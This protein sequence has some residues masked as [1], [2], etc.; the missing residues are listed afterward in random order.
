MN[1][2]QILI[3]AFLISLSICAL[4]STQ[5][6]AAVLSITVS[7]E[8]PITMD[9]GQVQMFTATPNG[10]SGS[11]SVQWN[12]DGSPVGSDSPNYS[13]SATSTG[14]HLI[15]VFV[16]DFT[17]NAQDSV[18]VTVAAPPTVSIA[19]N[20]PIKMDVGQVQVFTATSIGGSGTIKY[21]WYLGGSVVS[22]ATGSTYSFSPAAAGSYLVTC[23]VTDSASSPVTSP[24]SNA[25]SVVVNP[26]LVA[27]TVSAS[28]STD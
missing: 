13:F 9:V 16:T 5:V 2:S 8:G 22:G 28:A 12:L 14:P 19:P 11:L 18:S 4:A 15:T 25:V 10:G 20:G 26:A 7:P 27:P 17:E 21:Q 6:K 1:K 23:K 24:F 3:I